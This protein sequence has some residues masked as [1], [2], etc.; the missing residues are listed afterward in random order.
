MDRGVI[1][2]TGP[3]STGKTTLARQLAEQLDVPWV[4]EFARTWLE[5]RNGVYTQADLLTMAR[6]QWEAIETARADNPVVVADT[7][8]LTHLIWSRE[9]YGSDVPEMQELWPLRPPFFH[10]LC[11][12]DI[13]WEPDPLRETPHLREF[14]FE[15][16]LSRLNASKLPYAI[17]SGHARFEQAL[18]ALSNFNL[19]K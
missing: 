12:P 8:V 19:K 11:K 18:K 10:L 6:G 16:H 14:L 17:I 4:P 13:P 15:E 2:I 3:E 1:V 5:E 9:K 7:D